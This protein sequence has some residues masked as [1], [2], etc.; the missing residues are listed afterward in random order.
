MTGNFY[1]QV[2]TNKLNPTQ[3][4]YGLLMATE[5]AKQ[6]GCKSI[7][8][9]EFGV[10]NGRGLRLMASMTEQ[11]SRQSGVAIKVYGFDTGNGLTA[12]K[13]NRDIPHMFSEGGYAMS[14]VDALR[15]ELKGKAELVIGD[16]GA[17]DK[18]SDVLDP[19]VPLGFASVDVDLYSSTMSTFDLLATADDM[20]LLPVVNLYVHDSFGRQHYHRFAAQLLA[21]DDFNQKSDSRKI[22]IDRYIGYWYRKNEPWHASMYAMHTLDYQG[23]KTT[24]ENFNPPIKTQPE[25]L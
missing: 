14:S 4:A 12:P 3:F 15:L 17:I 18:L 20:A 11:L 2:K 16:I 10:F 25:E 6:Y 9:A 23:R 13:D 19:A 7:A 22:D 24:W 21:V 8:V 1:T 5:T